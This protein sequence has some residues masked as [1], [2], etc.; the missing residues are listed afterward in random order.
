MRAV[1]LLRV[2]GLL[3]AGGVSAMTVWY[4]FVLDWHARRFCHSQIMNGLRL[5]MADRGTN[6]F[7]NIGGHSRESMLAIRTEMGGYSDWIDRYSY[8]AGLTEDDPG[9]L[10]MLYVAEPTRWTWHGDPP[11]RFRDKA[12][13]LVPVDFKLGRREASHLGPGEESERVS[14]AEFA[15]RLRKT[16]DFLRDHQRPHWETVIGEHRELLEGLDFMPAAGRWSGERNQLSG[17]NSP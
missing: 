9:D 14:P 6:V 10:V 11:S 16:L 7:P 4:F 3:L 2:G 5:W 17:G 15:R 1:R 13:I 12:W 8:V